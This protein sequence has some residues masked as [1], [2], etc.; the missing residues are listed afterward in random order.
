MVNVAREAML[1]IG[2]IQ[3][4]RCHTDKCPTGVATQDPWLM[5]GL[6]AELKSVRAA[7]YITTLRRDLLKVSEA[8]G[9]AHPSLIGP[10]DVELVSG[11][12]DAVPLHQTFGYAPE[13]GVPG[14]SDR[15]EIARLMTTGAI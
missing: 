14:A 4:Q 2:C 13:W 8:C 7:N 12:S 5:R 3:S 1:A 10:N 9:V 6:D 15:T 11:T